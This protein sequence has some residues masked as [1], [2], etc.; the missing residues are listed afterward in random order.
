MTTDSQKLGKRVKDIHNQ[1]SLPSH[2]KMAHFEKFMAKVKF[3]SSTTGKKTE[4]PLEYFQKNQYTNEFSWEIINKIKKATG[5][6]MIIG[7]KGIMC[8]EDT[9]LAL[10]NGAEVIHV[11]NH[12]CRQLDTTPTTIEVLPEVVAEVRQ[13][14]RDNG[15][16]TGSI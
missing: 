12:G 7:A 5:N 6:T 8:R 14:E 13:W 16:D 4:S 2:L 3:N 1:F 15:R 9:R 10:D 11:N